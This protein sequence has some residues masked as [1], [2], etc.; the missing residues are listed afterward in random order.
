MYHCKWQKNTL[1]I[2]VSMSGSV[3][4]VGR[5]RRGRKNAPVDVR[6]FLG[7]LPLPPPTPSQ[8]TRVLVYY[9]VLYMYVLH[10]SLSLFLPPYSTTVQYTRQAWDFCKPT[11]SQSPT[12]ARGKN[13][14]SDRSI[15]VKERRR[16]RGVL[17]GRRQKG[18][19][20]QRQQRRSHFCKKGGGGA[21]ES[22]SCT[23]L[24]LPLLQYSIA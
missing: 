11:V 15:V 19:F 4:F 2:C 18:V 10:S 24:S 17:K 23:P 21:H 22:W 5:R 8:S 3:C 1:L 9:N 14:L 13:W 12:D 7:L 16:R 20:V 6:C